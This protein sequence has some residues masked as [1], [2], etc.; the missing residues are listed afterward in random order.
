MKQKTG[1]ILKPKPGKTI[2]KT[3]KASYNKSRQKREALK[4]LESL[5]LAD[6]FL[7]F[8]VMQ[9]AEL[10]KR[11]LEIILGVEIERIESSPEKPV[12]SEPD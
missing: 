8:K 7:F 3:L 4:S 2:V 1:K 12:L 10:C 5:T 11:L 9:D 6:R